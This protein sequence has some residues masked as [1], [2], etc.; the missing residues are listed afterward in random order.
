MDKH[1]GPGRSRVFGSGTVAGLIAVALVV[2]G[3]ASGTTG[4][5]DSSE[6]KVVATTTMLGSVTG[7]IVACAGGQVET[8][9]PVGA[10]PHEF[11]PSSRDV[12]EMT[13]ADL[14]VANG[15]GLEEG[16]AG[17]LESVRTD[18]GQ[19][20]EVAPLVNPI[21]FGDEAEH[22]NP[23]DEADHDQQG[24]DQVDSV[25]APASEGA[26][27][28]HEHSGDDPHFWMDVGRMADGARIIG[29]KLAEL[30]GDRKYEQCG[31]Q[32]EQQLNTLNK[33]LKEQLDTVPK[34]K[35]VMVTDHDALG[36]FAQAYDYEILETVIPGGSTLGDPSSAELA[37]LAK[38]MNDAG[39]T[40]VFANTAG[41]NALVDALAKEVP[42]AQ[43]VELYI[44]S[45]GEPGT[46]AGSYDGMMTVDVDR[47]TSA[48]TPGA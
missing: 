19:V 21:P 31:Q 8:I 3:C 18:G 45:I 16:M 27:D 38:T 10:D 47:I 30:T 48:L 20:L 41:S 34:N 14:V 15:L 28:S 43:V 13:K 25:T 35:R 29:Q 44:G 33:Q 24:E 40:T 22:E 39:A 5:T 17:A 36:Y 1:A 42:G 7:E 12:S 32:V 37:A 2:T 6:T 4:G 46:E 26:T 9:L 23:E 11:S